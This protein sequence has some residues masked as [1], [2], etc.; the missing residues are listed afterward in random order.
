MAYAKSW[1]GRWQTSLC[2]LFISIP[3]ECCRQLPFAMRI[4]PNR[5]DR[6]R[7]EFRL[8]TIFTKFHYFCSSSPI[9]FIV[10][11]FTLFCFIL[12][13]FASILISIG[14]SIAGKTIKTTKW[15]A[16]FVEMHL[17]IEIE[18]LINFTPFHESKMNVCLGRSRLFFICILDISNFFCFFDFCFVTR[19]W[20]VSNA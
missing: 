6:K 5:A 12:L 11:F 19:K 17:G 2:C 16:I 13:A 14:G 10:V 18:K 20:K 9:P 1:I 4:A 8:K 3:I 15:T 7:C